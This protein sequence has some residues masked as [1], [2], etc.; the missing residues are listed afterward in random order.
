MH[1]Y[2]LLE[3]DIRKTLYKLSLPLTATAFIQMAYN[4]ID[5]MW[6]GR[7]GTQAVAGAGL[8]GFIIWMSQSFT[9]I[10]KI[11]MGIYQS[12]AHGRKNL[13]ETKI[14]IH[15]GLMT[16]IVMAVI[17]TITV[18]IF[19]DFYLSFY[20][21]SASVNRYASEYLVFIAW[22]FIFTF[23]NPMFS[24]MYNSFGDSKTPFLI[25]S[26]GLVLNIVLDPILIFGLFSFPKMG[27]AGAAFATFI[28]NALVCL[29]F[30]LDIIRRR[31][32][33][34]QSVFHNYFSMKWAFRIMK[35]GYPA[36]L[37]NGIHCIITIILNKMMAQ[38]GDKPVA[39]YSIG[40][41]IESVSWMTTEGIQV[42]ISAMVGQNYGASRFKRVSGII[43]ESIRLVSIIGILAFL[44]LFT[45]R[46]MLFKVFI[47]NDKEAIALGA[48]YLLILSFS[49]Y[50][51][52]LEIGITGIFNGLSNTKTPSL[53]GNLLNF[54]R[55]PLSIL[56]IKFYGVYGIWISFT[57]TSVLKGI[58]NYIALRYHLKTEKCYEN[59]EF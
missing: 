33:I 6:I 24:Q 49:Q 11:G 23:L 57:I 46:E 59:I 54:A 26:V 42:A 52:S 34:R 9:F 32:I 43:K 10:P 7:I 41:M 22:G 17:F 15:T 28:S 38:F 3:G 40:S 21:L 20:K 2:I 4:F 27:I 29:I 51:M 16:A 8:I 25:N 14:I 58:L 5:A 13:K 53:I 48:V 44:I 19:K 36:A 37:L 45:F 55:I 18:F 50:F 30:L 31:P 56:L 39:V 12:Q 47:P 35:L 1:N